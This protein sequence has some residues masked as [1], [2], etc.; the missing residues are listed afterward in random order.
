VFSLG[1]DVDAHHNQAR[2]NWY[3]TPPGDSEPAYIGFDVL[4]AAD[5]R[6]QSVYGFLDKTPA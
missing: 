4:V 6:V 2:F 5:G 1:G 3:A